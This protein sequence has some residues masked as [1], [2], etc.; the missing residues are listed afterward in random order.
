L[1]SEQKLI[2]VIYSHPFLF[3]YN[4]GKPSEKF[5][6]LKTLAFHK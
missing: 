6:L 1:F 3:S 5:Q 4:H 2:K